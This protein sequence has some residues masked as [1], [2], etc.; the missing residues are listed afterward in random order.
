MRGRVPIPI[1]NHG[2]FRM[3]DATTGEIVKSVGML[4][5]VRSAAN[6]AVAV[7]SP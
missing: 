7:L 2:Y 5:T 3:L 6:N 4:G 1:A